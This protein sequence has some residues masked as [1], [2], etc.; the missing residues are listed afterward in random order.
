[1]FLNMDMKKAFD[2]MEWV[3][4]LSI[5]EKLRFHPTQ[6]N[7]IRLCISSSSFSIILN[8]SP[9]GRFSRERGLR[10]G[11]PLSSFL[12]ILGFEVLSRLL[13]R[14]EAIGNLRGLKISKNSLA[15]HHLF[16]VDDLLIFGKAT[17]KEA[18]NIHSYLEKYCLWSGQSINSSKSFIS[19]SKNTNPSTITLILNI[20]PDSPNPANSSYLRLSILFDNSKKDA[21]QNIIDRVNSKMDGWCAKTLSQARRLMLIKFVAVTIPSYTVS[22][23]LLPE[24]IYS[25]LDKT[26]KNFWWETLIKNQKPL[27]KVLEFSL[28]SKSSW[29]IGPKENERCEPSS[30]C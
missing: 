27:L 10:Q 11:D 18:N 8:G 2:K 6:V 20:L 7:W 14:K 15:I 17:P 4:I 29:W 1:M 5:M 28:H 3:F 21:F 12:F 9:F 22:T 26:F 25:Q 23:F 19:F 30:Y 16:F 24:S 13:F